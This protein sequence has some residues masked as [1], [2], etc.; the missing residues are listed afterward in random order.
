MV[1]KRQYKEVTSLLQAVN[2]LSVQFNS[3]RNVRQI[4]DL[5]DSINSIRSDLKRIVFSDFENSFTN[6]GEFTGNAGRLAE[7]CSVVEIIDKD[8]KYHLIVTY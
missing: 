4:S 5:L 2:Q 7:T 3:F 6:L 1:T 8:T